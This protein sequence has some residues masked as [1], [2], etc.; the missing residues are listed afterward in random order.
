[1]TG[2]PARWTRI[3]PHLD[4][5]DGLRADVSRIHWDMTSMSLFGAY[6]D[7]DERFPQVKYGHPR[8]AG[9]I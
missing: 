9:S 4:V 5:G 2:S 8:T 3:A 7:Q 1:M 6:E